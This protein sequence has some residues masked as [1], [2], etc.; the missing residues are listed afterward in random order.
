MPHIGERI[1]YLRDKRRFTQ[2]ELATRSGV[3]QSLISRLESGSRGNPSADVLRGLATALGCTTDYLIG[4]HEEQSTDS[5]YMA[6][7]AS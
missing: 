6:A 3:P 5:E 4:M 1:K 7:A 2:I